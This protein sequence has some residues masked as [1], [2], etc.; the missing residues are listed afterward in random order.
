MVRER[1]RGRERM[2]N[3]IEGEGEKEK[4]ATR[5]GKKEVIKRQLQER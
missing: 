2:G 4:K 1:I 5:Q 3:R